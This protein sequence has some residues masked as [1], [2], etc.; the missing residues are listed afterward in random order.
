[1]EFFWKRNKR[2]QQSFGDYLE[3]AELCLHS[4]EAGM[5]EWLLYSQTQRYVDL[6]FQT[7]REESKC[8]DLRRSI[9]REIYEKSLIPDSRGDV[10]GLLESLDK[11]PNR[12]ESV[13]REIHV[14]RM[15]PPPVIDQ[16]LAHLLTRCC[17]TVETLIEA[18]RSIFGDMSGVREAVKKIDKLESE[19]DFIQH[20]AVAALFAS[21]LEL[22][23]KMLY[24]E[25][26]RRVGSIPDLAESVG[27]RLTITSA[28]RL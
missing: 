6:T 28:K 5:T 25:I 14:M 27:D 23:E 26:V 12:M 17:A 3:Q 11:I 18:A 15:S 7:S 8:D 1:M 24:R 4:F 22:A 20:S 2:I 21:D 16:Q 13:M 9:E 19:C 10:L